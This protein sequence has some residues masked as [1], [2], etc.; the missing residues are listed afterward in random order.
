MVEINEKLKRMIEENA[1]AFATADKNGNPHCIA[2]G[3]VKVVSKNQVLITNNCMIK[4]IRNIQKNP[5]ISLAVWN[6]DWRENC[7]GYE[8][9]GTAQYF[10]RGRWY[11]IIKQIP[12]NK[13][14]PCKGAVLVKINKVKRLD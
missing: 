6:K 13:G 5:N 14:E 4:T 1:L 3:Y 9:N 10:T 7:I 11:N 8:L 2:V 12:E